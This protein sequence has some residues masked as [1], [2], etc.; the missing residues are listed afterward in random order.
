MRVTRSSV[1]SQIQLLF[2]FF[3]HCVE[4]QILTM[5]LRLTWGQGVTGSSMKKQL[6]VLFSSVP[7]G[8][9]RSKDCSAVLPIKKLRLM[10]YSCFLPVRQLSQSLVLGG[11][12]S[13]QERLILYMDV[14]N[15]HLKLKD[16]W[17]SI[18]MCLL[19]QL[20]QEIG[21][22]VRKTFGLSQCSSYCVHTLKINFRN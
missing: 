11:K 15:N 17:E 13:L 1:S 21:H 14:K 6:S 8:L 10:L 18:A 2:F 12:F 22:W 19:C 20:L 16:I 9:F 3:Y 7:E 4:D 5:Q